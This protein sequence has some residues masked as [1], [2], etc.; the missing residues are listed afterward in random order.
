MTENIKHRPAKDYGIHQPAFQTKIERS[1]LIADFTK[2]NAIENAKFF[3]LNYSLMYTVTTDSYKNT[4]Y[5][6]DRDLTFR[7]NITI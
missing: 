1:L 4:K 2:L 6:G 5:F 3:I 7:L